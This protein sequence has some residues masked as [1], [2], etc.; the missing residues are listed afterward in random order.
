MT[1]T[2]TR[3]QLRSSVPSVF[4]TTP[5]EG[6]SP[7]YRFI[8]TADVLDLLEGQGFRITSARQSRSRI[9][10]KAPFTRHLLRLR[11]ESVMD[12]RDEVP[13]VVLMNS[14]DRS[15][16][17]RVFSGV[18]RTVCENGLVIQS[19]DFGSFSIRHSGSRDL[20]QQVRDATSQIMEGVPAIMNRIEAWKGII[21]P[22]SRQVEFAREAWDLKPTPAI[23]PVWLLTARRDEDMTLPDCSR[24]LWKTTNVIHESLMRG[25]L[26]GR[27]E[28]GRRV[29]TRPVKAVEADLRINRRLWEMAEAFSRN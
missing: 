4:A 12:A 6:M 20:F 13:E 29:T 14:H 21:L 7:A 23:P 11:H 19:S 8:P 15:S 25:G 18:F 1:S 26:T 16:A 5:W 3:D 27:N 24:D 10:G 9:E 17:Y 28:R 22:R 2:I